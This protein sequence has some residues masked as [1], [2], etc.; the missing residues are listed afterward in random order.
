MKL[1][2]PYLFGL[3]LT[4]CGFYAYA[5][6]NTATEIPTNQTVTVATCFAQ[7]DLN[8]AK[9]ASVDKAVE[10]LNYVGYAYDLKNPKKLLYREEHKLQMLNSNTYSTDIRY[11]F[12]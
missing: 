2:K 9:A 5:V 8:D 3:L 4:L 7:S 1:N 10:T 11:H 12:K 6:E